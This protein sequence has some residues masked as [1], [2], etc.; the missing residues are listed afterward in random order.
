VDTFALILIG[1][2]AAAVLVGALVWRWRESNAS[3][4]GANASI[5]R[6]F[7]NVFAMMSKERQEAMISGLM[8]RKRCT[9]HQA[10]RIAVEERRH[11]R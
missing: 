4:K 8:A 6:D 7:R 9:R 2:A 3:S 11:H 1:V 5:E 10:M